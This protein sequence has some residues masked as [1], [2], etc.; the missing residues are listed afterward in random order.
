MYFPV[1]Y[2]QCFEFV[3]FLHNISSYIYA[4]NFIIFYGFWI[5]CY[6]WNRSLHHKIIKVF[7][8][9]FLVLLCLHFFLLKYLIH[10]KFILEWGVSWDAA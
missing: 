4:E 9:I 3:D 7:N 1:C 10:S 8:D 2:L 6:T 5:F